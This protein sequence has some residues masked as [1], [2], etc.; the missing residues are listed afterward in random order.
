M[1]GWNVCAAMLPHSDKSAHAA[2]IEAR[3]ENCSYRSPQSIKSVEDARVESPHKFYI[4]RQRWARNQLRI[5]ET[6]ND[7]LQV[8]FW[9]VAFSIPGRPDRIGVAWSVICA[10]ERLQSIP[11]H[12]CSV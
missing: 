10:Q 12:H 8:R 7:D 9:E 11:G 6:P 5:K 1:S 2:R 3:M 4:Q